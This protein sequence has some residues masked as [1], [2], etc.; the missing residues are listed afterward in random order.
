[1]FSFRPSGASHDVGLD[2]AL[3]QRHRL[4]DACSATR[5]TAPSSSSA[6]RPARACRSSAAEAGLTFDVTGGR[7]RGCCQPRDE[8]AVPRHR[9]IGS[10]RVRRRRSRRQG[11]R[12]PVPVRRQVVEQNRSWRSGAALRRDRVAE[13]FDRAHPRG[14][15]VGRGLRRAAGGRSRARAVLEVGAG[16]SGAFGPVAFTIEGI[17]LQMIVTF[18]DGNLGPVGHRPGVQASDWRGACRSTHRPS[19]AAAS[20]SSI[21]QR[22]NTPASCSSSVA[23]TT[24]AQRDRVC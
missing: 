12:D 4:R 1:M 18:E 5:R 19:P 13:P 7:G 24:H 23:E 10:R 20:C 8:G 6:G 11:N 21:R 16:L 9:S 2:G 14:H 15:P 17:G 3:R 22:T